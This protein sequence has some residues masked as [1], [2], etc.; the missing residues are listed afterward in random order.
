MAAVVKKVYASEISPY[1]WRY[2]R[3][4]FPRPKSGKGLRGRPSCDLRR[5]L[6]GILYVNKTGCQWRMLP[7]EYGA[8]STVYGYFN[9]WSAQGLWEKVL[10]FVRKR[11]RLRQGRFAEPSAGC[12]DSQSVK[13]ATQGRDIGIDGGKWVKGRK[14]HLLV[15]TLGILLAVVVTSANT[16]DQ[17]GFKTLLQTY[18]KV[19]VQRLRRIWVDGGYS[20]E[21]LSSWTAALKKTFK[22]VLEV[23][24]K[25]GKGF[26]LVKHRWVV[27][28]TF[29][30]LLNF[31]RNSKDYE[32]LV[33]NSV[34]MLQ[35]SMIHI[36]IRR[37]T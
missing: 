30:W 26:N 4:L 24:E 29:A 11:E 13:T 8:W 18:F 1:Q 33:R 31:R 27:E 6:N 32:V 3:H 21:P 37:L 5:I 23:V 25:Q 12:V 36:L 28:R 19:Q 17:E 9:R 35:I 16:S 15:D 7:K 20:G 10:T 14:R 34:A 22:I 2:I